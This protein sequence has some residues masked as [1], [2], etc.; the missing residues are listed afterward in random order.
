[1]R[2]NCLLKHVIEVRIGGR[3][4]VMGRWEIRCKKLLDDLNKKYWK[5]K[6]ET[7]NHTVKNS[8]WKRLWTCHK[9]QQNE[10]IYIPV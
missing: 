7:L 1:M 6:E 10:W 3:R 4:E 9:T 8:L 5:L 2:R